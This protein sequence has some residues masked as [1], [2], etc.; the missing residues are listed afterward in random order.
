MLDAMIASAIEEAPQ[1]A[2]DLP[3]KSTCRR[4]TSSNSDR[5]LRGR[6]IAHMIHEYFR[7]TRAHET[8]QG[9]ADLVSMAL[10]NAEVQDFDVRWDHA[11]LSVEWNAFRPDP[12][13]IVQVKVTEFRSTSDCDGF[14][15]SGSCSKQWWDTELSTIEN[16]S[17]TSHFEKSELQSPERCCGKGFSHQESKKERKPALRGKWF[18]SGKHKDNVP[19]ETPCTFSRDLLLASGN[20]GSSQRREGRSSSPASHPKAKQTDGE[21]GDKEENSHKRSQIL[22]R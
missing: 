3:K 10:Q 13:W 4:A 8:V 18:F 11:R 22:C 21:K 9:L 17:E 19:K 6:Q 5:F 15:W 14:V 12:G 16:C 20:R 7:A 2:V 1:H